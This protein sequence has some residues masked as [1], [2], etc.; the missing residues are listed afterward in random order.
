MRYWWLELTKSVLLIIYQ[1]SFFKR[2]TIFV[3]KDKEKNLIKDASDFSTIQSS[4]LFKNICKAIHITM[5]RW[6][7]EKSIKRLL[8]RFDNKA[9]NTT[10]E[11]SQ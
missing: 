7:H 10:F 2:E 11:S 1:L 8:K 3:S 9:Y 6:R 4:L 5:T